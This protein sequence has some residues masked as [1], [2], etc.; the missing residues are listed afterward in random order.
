MASSE[1]TPLYRN[2]NLEHLLSYF[3]W[4]TNAS[5]FLLRSP[6]YK[7]SV[8]HHSVL[9]R[10]LLVGAKGILAPP[11]LGSSLYYWDEHLITGT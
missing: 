9:V 3:H 11:P 7:E 10:V 5:T 1:E 6:L 8:L 4:S 2:L